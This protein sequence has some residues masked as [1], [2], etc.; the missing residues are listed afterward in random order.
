MSFPAWNMSSGH[1]PSSENAESQPNNPFNVDS[2]P[3]PSPFGHLPSGSASSSTNN[4]RNPTPDTDASSSQSNLFAPSSS[5]PSAFGRLSSVSD[6]TNNGWNTMSNT[7]S[8]QVPFIFGSPSPS[9]TLFSQNSSSSARPAAPF[10]FSQ[11]S[12]ILGSGTGTRP[13][14]GQRVVSQPQ[15]STSPA[16]PRP[17]FGRP[18]SQASNPP[19]LLG[20]GVLFGLPHQADPSSS[21]T[22]GS[23]FA[24]R[25]HR[26]ISAEPETSS[27]R[28]SRN[29][30]PSP[31]NIPLPSSTASF[32]SSRSNHTRS[33]SSTIPRSHHTRSTPSDAR[34]DGPSTM[35]SG[36]FTFRP[37]SIQ[38]ARTSVTPGVTITSPPQTPRRAPAGS[39]AAGRHTPT[40][41][42]FTTSRA[43][44]DL[45]HNIQAITI[46]DLFDAT[47]SRVLRSPQ[48]ESSIGAGG[49]VS[50][51]QASLVEGL[52]ELGTGGYEASPTPSVAD[53]FNVLGLDD[54]IT[55]ARTT[56]FQ[57]S[58]R[59]EQLPADLPYYNAQFQRDLRDG[60]RI[61][62][63][64]AELLRNFAIANE[65]GSS[66]NKIFQTATELSQYSAPTTR[67][68]GVVG[69]SGQGKSSLVNSLLDEREL[70][71]TGSEGGAVTSFVTEYRY[72]LRHHTSAYVVEVE[73]LNDDE[74]RTE[75]G[76]LLDD[77][78]CLYSPETPTLEDEILRDVQIQSATAEAT[79][80]AAFGDQPNWDTG[81]LRDFN[82]GGRDI[83]LAYLENWATT[84]QWPDGARDG[85]WSATA[86]CSQHCRRL[87]EEFMTGSIWP[88]VK[89]VRVYLKAVVLRPGL[90]LAD[91]P[92]FRDINYARVQAARRYLAKCNEIFIVSDI[93]RVVTDVTIREVI[94]EHVTSVSGIG[95]VST[96]NIC[97]ICSHA[98]VFDDPD[99]EQSWR[100]RLSPEDLEELNNAKLQMRDARRGEWMNERQYKEGEIRCTKV[101]ATAR[102][103]SISSSL[104]SAYDDV[105]PRMFY[106]DNKLYRD[107]SNLE[108][109]EVS[110][111]PGLRRFCYTIPAQALYTSACN[112]LYNSLPSLVRSLDLWYESGREN[113]SQ[114][115]LNTVSTAE[116]REQIDT[117]E[118]D[119]S[120]LF[121]L[122]S[123]SQTYSQNRNHITAAASAECRD[124]DSEYEDSFHTF[125]RIIS[126]LM[127]Q[128]YE[129]ACGAG[130]PR[131][132]LNNIRSRERAALQILDEQYGAYTDLFRSLK[133]NA[134]GGHSTSLI[135][136][137]MM[138][139][140]RACAGDSGTGV[141]ARR[142]DHMHKHV[143]KDVLN[144]VYKTIKYEHECLVTDMA[145][146]IRV[147]LGTICDDIENDLTAMRTADASLLERYPAF[148][149][150]L[151]RVLV[152][153]REA[154]E[155][156]KERPKGDDE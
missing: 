64:I 2:S 39:T 149:L 120:A 71:R 21:R 16:E 108:A 86:N 77:Y 29:I 88:F 131:S 38:S 41:P 37:V 101:F 137:K 11:T 15:A 27:Q 81:S 68:V 92:G 97:I 135:V 103:Q 10:D 83:A 84:L 148:F 25:P 122:E 75:L 99:F 125:R 42:I 140:Y 132:F 136:D 74:L 51:S 67:I 127:H 91:L 102:N 55:T 7:P 154:M 109:V 94:Q 58:A 59:T 4:G 50:E 9:S 150:D 63:T 52:A 23:F 78:R 44:S 110:G 89:V 138:P 12:G 87:I 20:A 93:K 153:T 56:K 139:A 155:R 57:Y 134:T 128:I 30:T 70:A 123:F 105:Q 47:P 61:A 13:L 146:T 40:Q 19:S 124:W 156:M 114:P 46:Q 17:L 48:S 143:D 24:A 69:N 142:K 98:T 141:D 118:N 80:T 18:V 6:S 31:A 151:G 26:A 28:Q 129:I 106:V 3:S 126:R 5:S 100:D 36:S 8:R 43:P 35:G 95:R 32:T 144:L 152:S 113:G 111:I 133:R 73:Y 62:T 60:K 82:K 130:A 1:T 90:I 33:A 145:S 121:S 22:T 65:A 112:F 34:S 72:S 116:L 76:Q 147:Q 85:N 104:R 115:L 49:S 54:A 119:F 53:N 79:L 96:P 117:I 66:L 45:Q 14:F 107:S